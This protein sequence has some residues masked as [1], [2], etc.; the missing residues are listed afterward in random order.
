LEAINLHVHCGELT[1]LLGPNGAGKTTLFRALLGELP[2]TGSLRFVHADSEERFVHPRIGY[3]PQKLD[4]DALAPVTVLDLLSGA[5]AQRPVWLG[6]PRALRAK[7]NDMLALVNAQ[8]LLDQRLG[9]LSCGELQR[10]LLALALMPTPD[11]LLLDEPVSGVDPSGIDLF[12]RMVSELRRT[13]DLSILLGSHDI[14]TAARFADRMICLNRTIL[15][16]GAPRE[17]LAGPC[18]RQ[19]FGVDLA[20]VG[21]QQME[22]EPPRLRQHQNC[23]H[24]VD[25]GPRGTRGKRQIYP[26]LRG[27]TDKG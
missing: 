14:P 6:H 1:V 7:A 13:Y 16:D 4:I 18:I 11:L 5:L 3:V 27:T 22:K 17:V 8:A 21:L 20:N 15:C 10:V 12:Y 25:A 9:R 19:T 23:A 24:Q 2:Y 26:A